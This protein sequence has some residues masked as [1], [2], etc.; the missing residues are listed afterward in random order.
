MPIKLPN[1]DDRK[2]A[3]LVQEGLNRIPTYASDWTNHN[4]SDPGITLIE[5][6][7]Y[8]TELLN[9]R[10]NRISQANMLVFLQLLNGPDWVA[11]DDPDLTAEVRKAILELRRRNRAIT[12]EDF[13]ML[14]LEA[15]PRI[16]RAQCVPRRDLTN[17]SRKAEDRPGHVSVVVVPGEAIEDPAERQ[18]LLSLIES[19]FDD[20]RL[21]TTRV[22]VAEA[23]YLGDEQGMEIH[24]AVI[25]KPGALEDTLAFSIAESDLDLEDIDPATP[26]G[27]AEMLSQLLDHARNDPDF[28]RQHDVSDDI[29]FRILTDKKW[30]II[31]NEYRQTYT[32]RKEDT[33]LYMY[34]DA[35]RTQAM[36][37]LHDFFDSLEGGSDGTGW[38]F[39]RDV[40]VSEVYQKIDTLP[41][42]DYATK[43]KD[44]DSGLEIDELSVPEPK[45]ANRRIFNEANRLVALAVLENELV[46]LKFDSIHIIVQRNGNL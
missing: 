27:A 7:A 4:P 6:F 9:Y 37:T 25:L 21:L 18:T 10:L 28:S 43:I 20:K 44:P 35:L 26:A 17:P 36:R 19:Y 1:L 2:Y 5:V 33:H 40:Y 3:D 34:K 16:A 32:V 22:H 31:D 46:R 38:P 45:Y 11:P 8:F 39:G 14:A 12:R 30:L 23:D 15:D 41:G 42:V 13:V 29:S 24:L